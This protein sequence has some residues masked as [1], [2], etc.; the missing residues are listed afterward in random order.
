MSPS[1]DRDLVF[2][3]WGPVHR[4][5]RPHALRHY[6]ATSWL[7]SGMGLDEVRRLLDHESISTTLRYSS[8]VA[9][10]LQHAHKKA[11]AIERLRLR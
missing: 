2:T 6:A 1:R 7:R 9:S 10:V 11:A 4:R 3:T 5:L 8:L